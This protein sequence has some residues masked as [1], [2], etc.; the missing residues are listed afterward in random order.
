M[1]KVIGSGF[2]RTGTSS[3]K[4]ALEQLG[5]GPCCHM[6]ELFP[7]PKLVLAFYNAA[8]GQPVDW[9]EVMKDFHSSVDFPASFFYRELM[10]AFPDAKVIH[11]VRDPE[12]WYQSTYE[13]VYQFGNIAPVWVQRL[14]KPLGRIIDMANVTLWQGLFEG[15]F[16][17]RRRAIEIFQ[18]HTET[19]VRSVPPERLAAYCDWCDREDA[20]LACSKAGLPPL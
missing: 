16:E 17:N 5:F 13:T 6:A 20:A 9:H 4:V 18:Q 3:M 11:T 10:D 1:L 7:K 15:N 19:V 14:I 12:R 8:H 2:G